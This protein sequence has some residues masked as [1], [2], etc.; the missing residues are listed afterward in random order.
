MTHYARDRFRLRVKTDRTAFELSH[1]RLYTCRFYDRAL[2]CKVSKK[3]RQAADL[4]VGIF[5]CVDDVLV[6]YLGIFYTLA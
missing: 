2:F 5:I 3:N 6:Q 4:R 1:A